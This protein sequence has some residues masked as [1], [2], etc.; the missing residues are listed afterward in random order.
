[1]ER[2]HKPLTREEAVRLGYLAQTSPS[3]PEAKALQARHDAERRYLALAA[4]EQDAARATPLDAV[5]ADMRSGNHLAHQL[6]ADA[7]R[8][9]FDHASSRGRPYTTPPPPEVA[10]AG[11]RISALRENR[12]AAATLTEAQRTYEVA[13]GAATRMEMGLAAANHRLAVDAKHR[14]LEIATQAWHQT[15]NGENAE[16][17]KRIQAEIEQLVKNTPK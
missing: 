14:E 15:P 2:K 12:E 16:Q 9:G 17:V 13:V 1:M 4:A 7:R 6:A 3:S 11:A 10:A 8:I 5:G